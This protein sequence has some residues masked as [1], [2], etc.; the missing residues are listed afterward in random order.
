MKVLE[1]ENKLNEF[2]GRRYDNE[3]ELKKDIEI[4]LG[5]N[6]NLFD[7]VDDMEEIDFRYAFNTYG[8]EE[9]KI[10]DVYVDIWYILDRQEK[11]YITEIDIFGD[12]PIDF[13]SADLIKEEE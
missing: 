3:L 12:Y 8:K 1:F 10:N 6:I 11:I 13:E 9:D 4:I 5:Y 2:V 7:G